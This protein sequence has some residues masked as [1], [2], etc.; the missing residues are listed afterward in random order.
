MLGDVRNDEIV[1]ANPDSG[2]THAPVGDEHHAGAAA[3]FHVL[4]HGQHSKRRRKR[5]ARRIGA[6]HRHV[7]VQERR[8]H[9]IGDVIH[10][11]QPVAREY[12][13]EWNELEI[14][15]RR[16]GV[17]V[18]EFRLRLRR[19]HVREHQAVALECRVGA[20]RHGLFE[21]R[22]LVGL[23]RRFDDAAVHV[24]VKSVVAAADSLF[25]DDPVFERRAAMTAMALQHADTALPVAERDQ[26]LAHDANRVGHIGELRREAHRLPEPAHEFAERRTGAG[27]RELGVRRRLVAL[28]VGAVGFAPALGIRSDLFS[29]NA[30][31]GCLA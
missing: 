13:G 1:D 8:V 21:A 10:R 2:L 16:E 7:V 25:L 15:V 30:A 6:V 28:M 9:L 17:I 31:H 26:V 24:V 3:D 5:R 23:A 12:V 22:A 20:L 19:A 11:L 14:R 29:Q 4:H 18:R 27:L